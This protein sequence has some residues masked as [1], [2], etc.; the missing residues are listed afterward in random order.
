[1]VRDIGPSCHDAIRM[2]NGR[3]P[4]RHAPASKIPT[5]PSSL[6]GDRRSNLNA[7]NAETISRAANTGSHYPAY[8]ARHRHRGFRG[9]RAGQLMAKLIHPPIRRRTMG[10]SKRSSKA[11][12]DGSRPRPFRRPYRSEV[13][14][15]APVEGDTSAFLCPIDS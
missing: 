7:R 3:L 1:M 4:H 2:G 13:R 15:V 5:S 6:I 11:L 12:S 14:E 10:S 9:R 8:P